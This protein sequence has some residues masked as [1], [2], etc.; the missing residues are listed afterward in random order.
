[1]FSIDF[2]SHILPGI[3]DGARNA[4]ESA[5][6][7]QAL[8]RQGVRQIVA[9]PHFR[10]HRDNIKDFCRRRNEALNNLCRYV[11]PDASD[12]LYLGAE[13]ALEYGISECG[14]M[15]LLCYEFT[16]HILLEF[17]YRPFS[18]WMIEEIANIACDFDLIPVIA[19]IDRYV[20][21][22]SKS[23]Y[24]EIFSM[25]GV[26]YQVN[27]EAFEA[28][29]SRRIVEK[30]IDRNLPFVLGSD[31][32]NT[33]KRRPNFDIIGKHLRGYVMQPAAQRFVRTYR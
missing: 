12:M 33:D 22:F 31:C 20:E 4:Q 6:M 21:V 10:G 23:D 9:T 16:N 29:S 18:R 25:G 11:G 17:P 26:I 14:D 1:M 2:H 19:H 13:V 15:S 32:H 28:R 5:A 30:L 3:D 7:M 24:D 8:S 27:N